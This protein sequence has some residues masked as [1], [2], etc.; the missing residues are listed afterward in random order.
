M[1]EKTI[2]SVGSSTEIRG[3]GSVSSRSQIVSPISMSSIPMI[4]ATSPASHR[5]TSTRPSLSNELS[6]EIL[7]A[8]DLPSA[9]ITLTDWPFLTKPLTIFPTAIRPTNSDQSMVVT[10]IRNLPGSMVGG[11]ICSSTKSSSGSILPS[12]VSGCVV[13][14]PSLAEA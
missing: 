11:S 6:A 10:P 8:R 7:Q 4:A 13:A 14:Y 5:S 12:N 1:I 2:W 9:P 3:S